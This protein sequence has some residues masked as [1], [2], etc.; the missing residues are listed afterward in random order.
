MTGAQGV[1]ITVCR[2]ALCYSMSYF[3]MSSCLLHILHNCSDQK[4]V[5]PDIM[6][7]VLFTF[8]PRPV[9]SDTLQ[10]GHNFYYKQ[11]A[12]WCKSILCKLV[13]SKQLD[14]HVY[15]ILINV[16]W[17]HE[18][19]PEAL[20][21]GRQC[22]GQSQAQQAEGHHGGS[23]ESRNWIHLK[24]TSFILLPGGMILK[25]SVF[26]KILLSVPQTSPQ[27]GVWSPQGLGASGRLWQN[28]ISRLSKNKQICWNRSEV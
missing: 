7:L 21:D 15:L 22:R 3:T 13:K 2:S 17:R 10:L 18:K 4:G 12:S 1:V 6:F 14:L 16:K 8:T 25:L 19:I 24:S 27:H 23:L 5:D 28:I 9:V 20:S 26:Y 11:T